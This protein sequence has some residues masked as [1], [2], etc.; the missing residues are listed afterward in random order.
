M[1][2]KFFWRALRNHFFGV[3]LEEGRA[4]VEGIEF[5]CKNVLGLMAPVSP[6]VDYEVYT[7]EQGGRR[8]EAVQ[9]GTGSVEK[10]ANVRYQLTSNYPCGPVFLEEDNSLPILKKISEIN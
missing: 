9:M 3:V 2:T 6:K 10:G 1:K 7:L 8:F 5:K 4:R